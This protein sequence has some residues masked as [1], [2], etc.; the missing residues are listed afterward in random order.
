[1]TIKVYVADI[2]TAYTLCVHYSGDCICLSKYL[3]RILQIASAELFYNNIIIIIYISK[4]L[5]L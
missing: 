5:K 3:N 2:T 1:M 4:A